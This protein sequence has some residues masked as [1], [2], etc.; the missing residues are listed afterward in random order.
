MN[1][2]EVWLIQ[3]CFLPVCVSHEIGRYV[4]LVETHS[5]H[6]IHFQSKG[7]A[8]FNGNDTVFTY[9]FDG[10]ANVVTDFAIC[11]R[12]SSNLSNL[13]FRLRD[14]DCH[15]LDSFNRCYD[16]CLNPFFQRHWIRSS[17][18]VTHTFVNHR[19]CKHSGSCCAVTSNII[20]FLSYFFDE[21]S[22]NAFYRIFE[23]NV[24]R[25]RDAI[26]SNGGCTPL[27][28]Q[29]NISSF[30]SEGYSN[31]VSKLVHA[32]FKGPTRFLVKGDHLCH[33]NLTPS[34]FS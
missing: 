24:F 8:L 18:D 17:S 12:N 14:A 6:E 20:S 3:N 23:F 4:S 34:L 2:K 29:N 13:L 22:T 25:Y 28:I 30:R 7:L 31:S 33:L 26:V 11:G 5:F 10:L 32:R 27:L 19:P 1:E 21:L 15:P 9:F 16:T